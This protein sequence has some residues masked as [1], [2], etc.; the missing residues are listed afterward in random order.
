[1]SENKDSQILIRDARLEE[2]DNV[3]RLLRSSFQ[4]YRDS[5]PPGA[6]PY[7]LEDIIDVR[8][9]WDDSQLIVAEVNGRLVGTITLYLKSNGSEG[10]WPEGWAGIRLLGVDP[11]YRSRGIG[12][13]LMDECI[14]RCKEKGIR[15]IG[16]RTTEMMDVS[17]KM[18][19]QMGFIPVPEFD[20]HPRPDITVL[21]YKLDLV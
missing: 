7:Y 5:L 21:A 11:G 1:M 18:Y 4:Q 16:L 13:A 20:H 14:K 10:G 8:G 2:L 12:R 9:R 3:A 19:E 6:W 15:T 17:K